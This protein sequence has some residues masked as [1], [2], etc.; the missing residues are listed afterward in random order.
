MTKA[1]VVVAHP[2][3]ETI[4]MGG[5]IL[6]YNDWDWTIVSL[7]REKDV[8][9]EPKFRNVCKLLNARGYIFDLDDTEEGYFKEITHQDVEE[10]LIKID[11]MNYDYIF[12]HGGNGEYGHIRHKQVSQA[13]TRMIKEEKLMCKKIYY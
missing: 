12:T 1:L 7:C 6:R 8:D 5:F 4:W 10:R 2:D 9:R 13:V 3:D 11:E